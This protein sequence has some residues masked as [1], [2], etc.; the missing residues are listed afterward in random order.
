MFG[1]GIGLPS[2][3]KT[4]NIFK[5]IILSLLS[6][7]P[8]LTSLLVHSSVVEAIFPGWIPTQAKSMP[9]VF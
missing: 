8:R 7:Q 9:M 5:E 1:V 2:R 4:K 6:L 3:L